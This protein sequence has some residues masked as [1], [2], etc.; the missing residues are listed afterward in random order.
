MSDGSG[1]RRD[2][3]W[4]LVTV[5]AALALLSAI[6]PLVAEPENRFLSALLIVASG[7][8]IW[9]A[10][11]R[12]RTGSRD[13]RW[14]LLPVGSAVVAVAIAPSADTAFPVV[15]GLLAVATAIGLAF[16]RPPTAG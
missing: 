13:R 5:V 15:F 1:L 3:P 14:W 4:L 9:M 16:S 11:G 8:A 12:L 10:I 6:Y 7:V 2:W